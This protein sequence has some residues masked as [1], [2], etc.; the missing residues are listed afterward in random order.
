MSSNKVNI[1]EF[2]FIQFQPL[3]DI[4]TSKKVDGIKIT[5]MIDDNKLEVRL[6]LLTLEAIY[7]EYKRKIYNDEIKEIVDE[8]I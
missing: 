6:T 1:N 5:Q 7:K 4:L 3:M 2:T 8:T